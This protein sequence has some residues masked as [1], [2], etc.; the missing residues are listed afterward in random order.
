MKVMTLKELNIYLQNFFCRFLLFDLVEPQ[1]LLLKVWRIEILF[2]S[3]K[4]PLSLDRMMLSS[5]YVVV[6]PDPL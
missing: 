4:A 6:G 2:P 3:G 1:E 5:N